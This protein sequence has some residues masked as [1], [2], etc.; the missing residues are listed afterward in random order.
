MQISK[1][2]LAI[3]AL[4]LVPVLTTQAVDTP[5]QAA[6]RA[7]LEEKLKVLDVQTPP[8][9]A[10]SVPALKP[11]KPAK[12]TK[13][14]KVVPVPAPATAPVV[15]TG[16][17]KVV[18]AAEPKAAVPAKPPVAKENSD[19]AAAAKSAEPLAAA[20]ADNPVQAAAREVLAKEL[21]APVAPPV[22]AVA[23]PV[24]S[25]VEKPAKSVV[26]PVAAKPANQNYLGKDL[27]MKPLPTPALPIA[28]SQ[29]A[30]LQALLAKYKADQISP[31]DYHQQRAKILAEP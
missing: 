10:E 20:P 23:Q 12:P 22:V 30:R 2:A 26:K 25:V 19:W 31:E 5:A 27:G 14:A 28:A 11:L 17:L 29:A 13:P 7:A 16:E 9:V 4:A 1:I 6:A 21:G 3:C 15:S 24:A 18:P 8:P